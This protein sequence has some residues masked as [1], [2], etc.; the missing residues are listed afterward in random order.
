MGSSS[1]SMRSS[2]TYDNSQNVSSQYGTAINSK[3][4]VTITDVSPEVVKNAF[5]FGG[6]AIKETVGLGKT[7]LTEAFDF[8]D[9]TQDSFLK[10]TDKI[11]NSLQNSQNQSLKAIENIKLEGSQQLQ[12]TVIIGGV[13]IGGIALT[14]FLKGK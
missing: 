4:N 3:G 8:G 14:I 5:D 7:A 11:T 6:L 9:R 13:I 12:K 2:D 10:F 1:S